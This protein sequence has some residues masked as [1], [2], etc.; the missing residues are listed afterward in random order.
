MPS[1]LFL[2]A[3]VE[4]KEIRYGMN[5]GCRMNYILKPFDTDELLKINSIKVS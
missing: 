1:F 4:V 3:K 5:L 2:T